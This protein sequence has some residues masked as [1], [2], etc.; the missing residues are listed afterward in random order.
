VI[1]HVF[2]AVAAILADVRIV[3]LLRAGRWTGATAVGALL[4]A[5]LHAVGARRHL[6]DACL[7]DA[8]L[9]IGAKLAETAVVAYEAHGYAVWTTAVAVGLVSILDAITAR[10]CLAGLGIAVANHA[11]AIRLDLANAPILARGALRPAAVH[12]GLG[13]VLRHVNAGH[14]RALPL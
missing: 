3:G 13:A 8:A 14:R 4:V 7:A 2:G 5:V 9:A 1:A 11:R 6:A 12:V 10:G